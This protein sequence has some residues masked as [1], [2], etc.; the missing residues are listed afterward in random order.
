MRFSVSEKKQQVMEMVEKELDKD[1]DVTLD[2][3]FERALEIDSSLGKLDKRQFHARY[4]L[5]VKRRNAPDRPRKPRATRK[6]RKSSGGDAAGARARRISEQFE[7]RER[8]RALFL[9]FASEFAAA[10]SRAE[11]VS[12]LGSVDKYVER[13]EELAR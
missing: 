4:P 12:F 3:L 10:E 9:E 11:I 7:N 5:Q 13:A 1:P 8:M 6:R 2:A